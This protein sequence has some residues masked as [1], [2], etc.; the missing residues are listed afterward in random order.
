MEQA[1][2]KGIPFVPYDIEEL[3][4]LTCHTA[5]RHLPVAN[6]KNTVSGW[7]YFTFFHTSYPYSVFIDNLFQ[8]SEYHTDKTVGIML[9]PLK[10][11]FFLFLKDSND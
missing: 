1:K 9:S 4:L 11:M 3:K 6:N 2:I 10:D 8:F 7:S 5:L